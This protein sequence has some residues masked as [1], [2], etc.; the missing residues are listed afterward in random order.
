ME[1]V[2]DVFDLTDGAQQHCSANAAN[3]NEVALS[4]LPLNSGRLK[5]R[6]HS[7]RTSQLGYPNY[8]AKKST[9]PVS[10]LYIAPAILIAPFDSFSA[11]TG[12]PLRMS[13]IVIS[14][15][16]RATASTNA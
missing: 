10:R 2:V 16:L 12:L 11:N 6:A 3:C 4:L 14:T 15:F 7:Q 5:R 9:T 8:P 1:Y 13:A